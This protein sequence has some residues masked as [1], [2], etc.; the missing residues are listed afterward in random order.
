M[1]Q[2]GRCLLLVAIAAS[3]PAFAG[4]ENDDAHTRTLGTVTVTATRP[5]SYWAFHPYT[6]RTVAAD[7]TADF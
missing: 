3:L 6:Q 1:N 5:S 4:D 2:H 7:L